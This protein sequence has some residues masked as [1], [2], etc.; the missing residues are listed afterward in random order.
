MRKYGPLGCS[1]PCICC[2]RMIARV[3]G[4]AYPIEAVLPDGSVFRGPL[5]EAPP[6]K[7]TSGQRLYGFG[8][9]G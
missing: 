1:L 2:R 3:L 9:S 5:S 6:S 8:R 7:M 4:P